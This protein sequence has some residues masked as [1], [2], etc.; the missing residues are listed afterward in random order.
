[1]RYFVTTQNSFRKVEVSREI[2][3]ILRFID[4]YGDLCGRPRTFPFEATKLPHE[5]RSLQRRNYAK[6]GVLN[7]GRVLMAPVSFFAPT[8]DFVS[9]ETGN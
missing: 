4:L 7:D 1:M 6:V 8:P 9:C 5:I 2:F 3:E